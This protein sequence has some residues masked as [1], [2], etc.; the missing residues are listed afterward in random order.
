MSSVTTITGAELRDR[1]IRF[2]Q[3]ALR[4]IPG[5]T[6]VQAGSYGGVSSLFLR[7]GESDY[8]KVLIDGVPVNQSGGGIQLGQSDHRQHRADRGPA[9]PGERH[10][11]L[12]CGDRRGA[13]L[14]PNRRARAS[15]LEGGAEAG[16]FG[17]VNGMSQCWAAP[18]R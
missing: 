11:R 18:A 17:T 1:G 13:D 10:L 8:V 2:V 4:D 5:A 16:T 14:H 3:D 15:R 6:V 7:G 9:G 12:R